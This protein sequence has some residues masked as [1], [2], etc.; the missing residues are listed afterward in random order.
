MML[1]ARF[2]P[3]YVPILTHADALQQYDTVRPDLRNPLQ[4]VDVDEH[5]LGS[6]FAVFQKPAF[7]T[8]SQ[9]AALLVPDAAE[10]SFGRSADSRSVDSA[11]NKAGV[12]LTSAD[13]GSAEVDCRVDFF[14]L[15]F[16]GI[17]LFLHK[18]AQKMRELLVGFA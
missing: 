15:D 8:N 7:D 12:L 17:D 11:P 14:G 6:N 4:L 18:F 2:D 9:V 16:G 13:L 5:L 10:R 3:G 1:L